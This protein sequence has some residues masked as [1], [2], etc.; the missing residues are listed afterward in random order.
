MVK[1]IF[2]VIGIVLASVLGF[3]GCVVG[4]L[5]IMGKFKKPVVYPKQL[6]FAETEMM[7][8]DTNE[9]EGEVGEKFS[10]TIYSF[11]L[12]GIADEGKTVTEKNCLLTIKQGADLIAL[13]DE[14]G[15]TSAIEKVN[16][17]YKIKCNE[18]T[19]F[20]LK[21]ITEDKP[22]TGSTYGLVTFKAD[23]ERSL[24]VRGQDLDIWID[25]QINKNGIALDTTCIAG[26][27]ISTTEIGSN[28]LAQ[29]VE[30]NLDEA[31]AFKPVTNPKYALS[32]ISREGYQ[33]KVVEYYYMDDTMWDWDR[34]D[35]SNLTKYPFLAF[36]EETGL[37]E[38]KAT[39]T[40]QAGQVYKFRMA[41]FATFDAREKYLLEHAETTEEISNIERMGSMIWC[42]FHISVK[43]ARVSAIGTLTQKIELNLYETNKIILNSDKEGYKNLRLFMEGAGQQTKLRFDETDFNL[44]TTK[45]VKDND[46]QVVPIDSVSFMQYTKADFDDEENGQN[47]L[48]NLYNKISDTFLDFFVYDTTEK[49]YKLATSEQFDY[50]AKYIEGSSMD[51]RSFEIKVKSLPNLS[52]GQELKL[53]VLVVNSN[54][55]YYIAPIDVDA[56]ERELSFGFVDDAQT[57][58]LEINYGKTNN[59]SVDELSLNEIIKIYSGSYRACVFV[60]PQQTNG[61]YDVDVISKVTFTKTIDNNGTPKETKY[62]L[63]GYLDEDNKFVNKVRAREGATTGAKL[64]LLQLK[65]SYE[66]NAVEGDVAESYINGL[67]YDLLN[68]DILITDTVDVGGNNE[69]LILNADFVTEN[70]TVNIGIN[71]TIDSENSSLKLD[72][73]TADDTE[74]DVVDASG[75]NVKLVA[76]FKY[77]IELKSTITDLIKSIY[78][79]NKANFKDFFKAYA[80]SFGATTDLSIDDVTFDEEANIVKVKFSVVSTANSAETGR[81]YYINFEF[82]GYTLSSSD[83]EILSNKP[84]DIKFV[85]KNEEGELKEYDIDNLVL[86][87]ELYCYE[88]GAGKFV[89]YNKYTNIL[90]SNGTE[91]C[92]PNEI[93]FNYKNSED[94]NE[95]YAQFKLTPDYG[96][97]SNIMEFALDSDLITIRKCTAAGCKCDGTKFILSYKIKGEESG[98]H[99]EDDDK[100]NRSSLHLPVGDYTLTITCGN[101]SKS[102]TIKVTANNCFKYN[103]QLKNINSSD[104]DTADGLNLNDYLDYKYVDEAKNI[105]KKIPTDSDFICNITNLEVVD[106]GGGV[107]LE[108]R[109]KEIYC[110]D[111]GKWVTVLKFDDRVEGVNDWVIKRYAF[112]NTTL[113]ISF[114]IKLFTEQE[115]ISIT[116]DCN[117]S[118]Q[119]DLNKNWGVGGSAKIYAGTNVTLLEQ[120][121]NASDFATNA[122]FKVVDTTGSTEKITPTIVNNAS[123]VSP[124]IKADNTIMFEAGSYNIKFSQGGVELSAFTIEVLPNVFATQKTIQ[125]TSETS[126][127]AFGEDKVWTLKKYNENTIDGENDKAYGYS[128]DVNVI[129]SDD[130]LVELTTS[131]YSS[132]SLTC[133]QKQGDTDVDLI[134]LNAGGIAYVGY[135]SSLNNATECYVT[136][137]YNGTP[138]SEGKIS[139]LNKYSAEL[140]NEIAMV[141]YTDLTSIV[142]LTNENNDVTASSTNISIN[143]YSIENGLV[144][145]N[146]SKEQKV[147]ATFTFKI[148]GNDYIYVAEITLTPYILGVNESNVKG[149]K[150]HVNSNTEFDIINGVFNTDNLAT[151]GIIN[152]LTVGS[153]GDKTFRTLADGTIV[154]LGYDKPDRLKTYIVKVNNIVGAS[155]EIVV[156][157][158]LEYADDVTYDYDVAI[159]VDNYQNINIQRPFAD[160][161]TKQDIILQ[162]I[163]GKAEDVA[164]FENAQLISG[165]NIYLVEKGLN[166]EPVTMRQVIDFGSDASLDIRRALITEN[167][168][169]VDAILDVQLIAYESKQSAKSYVNYI[170]INNSGEFA[171][172]FNYSKDFEK[173]SYAYFLFKITTTSGNFGYYLVKL[174]NPTGVSVDWSAERD[175]VNNA[176]DLGFS[177]VIPS[178]TILTNEFGVTKTENV[179]YYILSIKGVENSEIGAFNTDITEN[180]KNST[181]YS[182]FDK[183][184]ETVSVNNFASIKLAVVYMDGDDAVYL[185]TYTTNISVD[186]GLNA[187]ILTDTN[188]LGEYTATISGLREFAISSKSATVENVEITKNSDLFTATNAQIQTV[189]GGNAI[190]SLNGNS[191]NAETYVNKDLTFTVTYK[192]DGIV[193][194]VHYTFNAVIVNGFTD[195]VIGNFV[196]GEGFKKELDLT[197]KLGNYVGAI[198]VD[199]AKGRYNDKKITYT[200]GTQTQTDSI[201]VSLTNLFDVDL[202]EIATRQFNVTIYPAYYVEQG[203]GGGTTSSPYSASLN[204]VDQ[205]NS[206]VGSMANITKDKGANYTTY[207]IGEGLKIYVAND[208]ILQFSSIENG[209]YVVKD[210]AQRELLAS[211]ETIEVDNN[212]SIQFIHLAQATTIKMIIELKANGEL[213]KDKNDSSKNY[214]IE[215]Y[216]NVPASYSNFSANYTVKDAKHDNFANKT[217]IEKVLVDCLFKNNGS[218]DANLNKYRMQLL[219]LEIDADGNNI[220]I[221]SWNPTAMGLLDENN[222]NHLLFTLGEGLSIVSNNGDYDL[223]IKEVSQD[224]YTSFSIYN[225]AGLVNVTYNINIIKGAEKDWL[226]YEP[227][228][229]DYYTYITN[230]SKWGVGNQYASI[231]IN[232]TDSTTAFD[233][234]S[235]SN[236]NKIAKVYDERNDVLILEKQSVKFNGT[237]DIKATFVYND[238]T[239]NYDIATNN[240]TITISRTRALT[241]NITRKSGADNLANEISITFDVYTNA[242][243]LRTI[244][245]NIYNYTITPN[246]S[247][248]YANRI[249]NLNDLFKVTSNENG[250]VVTGFK[251]ALSTGCYY[252]LN[253]NTTQINDKNFANSLFEYKEST[254][255]L[256][257][258]QVPADV[259]LHL[260]VKIL[261]GDE[262]IAIED[263][264]MKILR[265]IQF[266]LNGET[267]PTGSAFESIYDLKGTTENKNYDVTANKATIKDYNLVGSSAISLTFVDTNGAITIGQDTTRIA[268]SSVS[269]LDYHGNDISNYVE[270]DGYTLK[271]KRDFTGDVNL[272][273]TFNTLLGDY[274][275][276]WVLKVQGLQTISYQYSPLSALQNG[277]SPYST[278]D[279]VHIVD[280]SKSSDPA[281]TITNNTL[282]NVEYAKTVNYKVLTLAEFRTLNS[283]NDLFKLGEPWAQALSKSDTELNITLALP[284]VPQSTAENPVDYYVVYKI[285]YVYTTNGNGLDYYAIYRVRNTATVK[286]ADVS[287]T[288]NVDESTN[289]IFN[290]TNNLLNLFYFEERYKITDTETIFIKL[291][292]DNGYKL[293]VFNNSGK[294]DNYTYPTSTDNKFTFTSGVRYTIDYSLGTPTITKGNGD[295]VAR[296]DVVK[297]NNTMFECGFNNILR[298]KEFIESVSKI[299]INEREFK[300]ANGSTCLFN[301]AEGLFSLNLTNFDTTEHSKLFTNSAETEIQIYT[302]DSATLPIVT[303]DLTFECNNSISAKGS[304]LLSEIFQDGSYVTDYRIIGINTTATGYTTW[305]NNNANKV[306]VVKDENGTEKVISSFTYNGGNYKVYEL[307]FT[308]TTNS[309]LYD[310]SAQFYMLMAQTPSITV[311]DYASKG[312]NSSFV[313]RYQEG[314]PSSIDLQ[315]A[316]VTFANDGNGKLTKTAENVTISAVSADG[317]VNIT[318]NGATVSVEESELINYKNINPTKT[319]LTGT[320][321]ANGI[322]VNLK[323]QLP[324]DII[325]LATAPVGDD[326][327]FELSLV[328]AGIENCSNIYVADAE[329]K[330]E[331]DGD[332]FTLKMSKADL[333]TYW[334]ANQSATYM[335]QTYTLS[336]TD[337]SGNNQTITFVIRWTLPVA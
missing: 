250:N 7:I 11:Q 13:C 313:V 320:A 191:I 141:N 105:D 63:V 104:V 156:R 204:T 53:C 165:N 265:N 249:Y 336:Y 161:I 225:N 124:T 22:F 228:G 158:H 264:E 5:A 196:K 257:F 131:D 12:N 171:V 111:G 69:T 135:I 247:E 144:K 109:G 300:L 142:K 82:G 243:K 323:F 172:T 194:K 331:F 251:Y 18:K 273:L 319:Q 96:L 99:I 321:T 44:R 25:R 41:V 155:K 31:I 208:T 284:T 152:K 312:Q 304:F 62:V 307:I 119:I 79:A 332:N 8:V 268:I 173:G 107:K 70:K 36:N 248:Y 19:Y 76:G 239:N 244:T 184:N 241:F 212:S 50:I 46:N 287:Q 181:Q 269:V 185:G 218:A 2:K 197:S 236:I 60:T 120:Q 40:N 279:L 86:Y 112:K 182:I 297:L 325:Y 318:Y 98:I 260:F 201:T 154:G 190:I 322:I 176:L 84:S 9:Y 26:G 213:I 220:A 128:K 77:Q 217:T 168:T 92:K 315:N 49:T 329:N 299:V 242:G 253:G 275:Q 267:A 56:N 261:N 72:T 83:I 193:I 110:I 177:N 272:T 139:V 137:K 202:D 337:I 59:V 311:V 324:A 334:D 37:F 259:S 127:T 125:L 174:I 32:P 199:Q 283:A 219:G 71:Y 129:Y 280:T 290:K 292:Y 55:E 15:N 39:E 45:L 164:G 286:L 87:N 252:T 205:Y 90:T 132:F 271:F 206:P 211:N 6:I 178:N 21:E 216:V 115:P 188:K 134:T 293:A 200:L 179:N 306:D 186:A 175:V 327:S 289:E 328:V 316:I 148:D 238:K 48:L 180:L 67:G 189:N 85:Y 130:D 74:F 167:G 65:N 138:I 91:I 75:A 227:A 57:R 254:A 162:A 118:I 226:I 195:E 88:N 140:T 303:A 81:Y 262:V 27:N 24:A 330:V 93:I 34:L 229:D 281:L 10:K 298:F 169:Q 276:E 117:S 23:D 160:L 103:E 113:K 159:V 308:K 314:K 266:R 222:P 1:R 80:R 30:V 305:V 277:G 43:S 163:E 237:E 295:P 150:I 108:I 4:V 335:K 38:F 66:T 274:T 29:V 263:R 291:V 333:E 97:D 170:T 230:H 147:N 245:F 122:L 231:V 301:S 58:T 214:G 187:D 52:E 121:N 14:T 28:K 114:K 233:Y 42:E 294:V 234:S 123:G 270:I 16:N 192:I 232:D 317:S 17:K 224:V 221:D 302:S 95:N 35:T 126:Y 198:S 151:A 54:G 73:I 157:Y 61:D 203:I 309:S 166:Y 209:N 101:V 310:I 258:S 246:G 33:G 183:A 89:Y 288:I 146:I 47:R 68:T 256:N 78:N 3:T 255:Q 215:F 106:F 296:T 64:Y 210:S 207:E 102:L 282:T 153:V 326:A 145:T 149:G 240:Y 235:Q 143:G 51:E 223:T 94:L 278:G 285:K 100:F 136:L 133:D 116:L 20:R